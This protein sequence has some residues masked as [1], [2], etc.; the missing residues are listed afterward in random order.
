MTKKIAS[1]QN[2]FTSPLLH[3]F[4]TPP[5]SGVSKLMKK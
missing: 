2:F 5:A 4:I 1:F 3:F